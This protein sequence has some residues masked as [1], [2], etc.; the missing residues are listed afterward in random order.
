VVRHI[1]PCSDRILSILS[2]H[3]VPVFF[4]WYLHVS[5][6]VSTRYFGGEA[7]PLACQDTHPATFKS[8][9][10]WSRFWSA[11]TSKNLRP[12]TWTLAPLQVL[13]TQL[14]PQTYDVDRQRRCYDGAHISCVARS[15]L[16]CLLCSSA[17]AKIADTCRSFPSA[18]HIQPQGTPLHLYTTPLQHASSQQ[19]WHLLMKQLLSSEALISQI[20]Q[21]QLGNLLLKLMLD[22]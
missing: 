5:C 21:K 16:L 9:E 1:I 13:D 7:G 20:S 11:C 4:I 8:T 14:D 22:C 18:G 19:S 17:F 3:S 12:T 2:T 6:P 15:S 10:P